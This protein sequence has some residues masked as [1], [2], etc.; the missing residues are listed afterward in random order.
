MNRDRIAGDWKQAA[1]KMKEQWGRLINDQFLVIAGKRQQFAGKAQQRHGL[2]R[3]AA[4]RQHKAW[5][6]RYQQLFDA[7]LK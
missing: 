3:E 1:G 4:Q 7:A 6:A 2:G 5:E